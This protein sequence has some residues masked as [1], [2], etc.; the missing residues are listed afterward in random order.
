M[1]PLISERR[2]TYL[3]VILSLAAVAILW[4]GLPRARRFRQPFRF[5]I[6]L[7]FVAAGLIC[8]WLLQLLVAS[9]VT[10]AEL[11]W[12]LHILAFV[13]A[14]SLFGGGLRAISQANNTARDDFYDDLLP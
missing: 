6:G 1:K 5:R 9:G 13:V 2:M 7:V 11:R 12:I 3:P 4:I 8:L 10:N 14:V